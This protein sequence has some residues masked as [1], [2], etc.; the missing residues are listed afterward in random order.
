[1]VFAEHDRMPVSLE[2]SKGS[3]WTQMWV[4]GCLKEQGLEKMYATAGTR[5]ISVLCSSNVMGEVDAARN[6]LDA[7]LAQV[8]ASS[9]NA[10]G[11]VQP[12]GTRVGIDQGHHNY[13]VY[14]SM[15]G[16]SSRICVA[17]APYDAGPVYTAG[18]LKNRKVKIERDAEGFVLRSDGRRAALVHQYNRFVELENFVARLSAKVPD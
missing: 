2:A 17:I 13:L 12:L 7:I 18:V 9:P 1:M 6:F 14:S 5:E 11:C 15:V 10:V 4:R 16:A 8:D 3:S